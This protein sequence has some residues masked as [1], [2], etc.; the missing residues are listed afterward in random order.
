MGIT[1]A[2]AKDGHGAVSQYGRR[3][4]DMVG[5]ERGTRNPPS[6]GIS[7]LPDHARGAVLVA[8]SPRLRP[9]GDAILYD[10][11]RFHQL[12][13]AAVRSALKERPDRPAPRV[14]GHDHLGRAV[15]ALVGI[16]DRVLAA[17]ESA[18]MAA[19]SL[20]GALETFVEGKP[21]T[22][23]RACGESGTHKQG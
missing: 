11:G 7:L 23:I 5:H 19:E 21:S 20:S 3:L 22:I 14:E 1:V 12:L 13:M 17:T 16:R 6:A 8:L 10:A 9:I 15:R 2:R 18:G 4:Q